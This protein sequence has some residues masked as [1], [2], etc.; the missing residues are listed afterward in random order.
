MPDDSILH[1]PF[2]QRHIFDDD[3][4]EAVVVDGVPIPVM[5]LRN[6]DVSADV[7]L[8]AAES[9]DLERKTGL[10]LE[11]DPTNPWPCSLC[12]RVF[13]TQWRWF[14]HDC[15]GIPTEE[16]MAAAPT[17]PSNRHFYEQLLLWGY[18]VK[19]R[20]SGWIKL[21]APN[22][23]EVSVRPPHHHT[24]N[25]RKA[26]QI[27]VALLNVTWAEFW[28][29]QPATT[30]V[31][32]KAEAPAE[33]ATEETSMSDTDSKKTRSP[34]RS[35][36]YR[37]ASNAVLEVMVAANEPMTTKRLVE[38]TGLPNDTINHA[39]H[40]LHTLDLIERV[41]YGCYKVKQGNGHVEH[42]VGIDIRSAVADVVAPSPE[43]EPAQASAVAPVAVVE[44]PLTQAVVVTPPAATSPID[45]DSMIN[46]VLDLL[47]PNGFKAKHLPLI[48]AWRRATVNLLSE[49][50]R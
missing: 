38:V 16:E 22:G 30:A 21:T 23:D 2:F 5:V 45:A 43:L 33:V 3:Y 44:P 31:P 50:E 32:P 11:P 10:S 48:D 41:K 8:A 9:A 17:H 36:R 34:A 35:Q 28:D 24:G 29:K 27:P 14:K 1:N 7:I 19:K 46:D 20:S 40:Y 15:T 39:C 12:D 25:S 13:L 26:L 6:R 4:D 37:G 18:K 47:F 42:R 49:V